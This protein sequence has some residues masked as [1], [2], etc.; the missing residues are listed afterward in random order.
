MFSMD[1]IAESI[2]CI[3][4]QVLVEF[5]TPLSP[6]LAPVLSLF[7]SIALSSSWLLSSH[8]KEQGILGI[9]VIRQSPRE[10]FCERISLAVKIG[11][12]LRSFSIV[13]MILLEVVHVALLE[14]IWSWFAAPQRACF[15]A[16]GV[17]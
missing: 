15:K 5:V 6:L 13:Y 16:M 7:T 17:G 14:V 9:R 8:A 10:R 2:R 4:Q 1:L 11:F 3:V 12:V